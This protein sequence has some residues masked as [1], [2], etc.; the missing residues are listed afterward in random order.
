[1]E[2]HRRTLCCPIGLLF[3]AFL[4]PGNTAE[5]TGV[6]DFLKNDVNGHLFNFRLTNL[7]FAGD[8]R[9]HEFDLVLWD[10]LDERMEILTDR[11]LGVQIMPYTDDAR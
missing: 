4:E 10:R 5:F 2:I 11:G 3:S 9:D 1:M 7:V 8:W 6:A